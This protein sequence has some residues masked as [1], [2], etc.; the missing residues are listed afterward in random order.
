MIAK[1]LPAPQIN[2]AWDTL[3]QQQMRTN[4]AK[5]K[6]QTMSSSRLSSITTNK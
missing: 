5:C 1:N 4:F 2:P 3:T 6:R